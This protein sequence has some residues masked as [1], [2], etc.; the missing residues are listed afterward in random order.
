MD[1]GSEHKICT[2]KMIEE[3]VRDTFESLA[4]EKISEDLNSTITKNNY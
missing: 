1:Q 4:Q 2:L 3:R